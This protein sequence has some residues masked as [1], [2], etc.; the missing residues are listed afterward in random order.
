MS[1][2]SDL[3]FL[4]ISAWLI[5]NNDLFLV[6]FKV[7]G[8]NSDESISLIFRTNVTRI[9]KDKLF[10]QLVVLNEPRSDFWQF[11]SI[12]IPTIITRVTQDRFLVRL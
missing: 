12:K 8:S 5:I 4:S 1:K 10:V 3:I 2:F 11:I 9:T 7:R 6:H